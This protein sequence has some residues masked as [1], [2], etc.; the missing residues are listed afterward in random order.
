MKIE[1][2]VVTHEY[3]AR[4]VARLDTRIDQVPETRVAALEMKVTTLLVDAADMKSRLAA[5]ERQQ[6]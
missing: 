2:R 4:E 6:P 1:R 3:V 5:L